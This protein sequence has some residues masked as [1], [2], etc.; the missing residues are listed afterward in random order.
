MVV[1]DLERNV[2]LCM[3]NPANTAA[4]AVMAPIRPVRSWA[5][6]TLSQVY[7]SLHLGL[8]LAPIVPDMLRAKLYEMV[9]KSDKRSR[10][11]H[12]KE[13]L[14]LRGPVETLLYGAAIVAVIVNFSVTDGLTHPSSDPV[15]LA[16]AF[17]LFMGL[18]IIKSVR[19]RGASAWPLIGLGLM[20]AIGAF[21]YTR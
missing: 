17:V 16:I 12:L 14:D 19:K 7:S 9:E 1:E 18:A 13:G 5:Y 10:L 2:A 8:W 21:V 15:A 11:K 4:E 3:A 6:W 20:V